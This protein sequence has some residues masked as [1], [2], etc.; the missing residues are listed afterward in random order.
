MSDAGSSTALPGVWAS[1]SP[2]FDQFAGMAPFADTSS[3]FEGAALPDSVMCAP[4]V[5]SLGPEDI[6]KDIGLPSDGI[7]DYHAAYE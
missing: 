3:T 4:R 1:S 7:W 5:P 2:V 6:P